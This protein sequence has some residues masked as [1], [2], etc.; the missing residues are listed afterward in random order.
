[1][2]GIGNRIVLAV[3]AVLCLLCVGLL[4]P[5]WLELG[6]IERDIRRSEALR[7]EQE[8]IEPLDLHLTRLLQTSEGA[9]TAPARVPLSPERLRAL[10]EL[11]GEPARQLGL[12]VVELRPNVETLSERGYR[13]LGVGVTVAGGCGAFQ[14]YLVDVCRMA[15]LKELKQVTIRRRSPGNLEMTVDVSLQMATK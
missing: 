3:G 1:M 4:V 7:H 9:L 10:P 14:K 13:E 15:S 11:F 12:A 2:R 5:Q 6:R 8:M